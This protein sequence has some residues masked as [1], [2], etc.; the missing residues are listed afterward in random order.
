MNLKYIENNIDNFFLDIIDKRIPQLT[1]EAVIEKLTKTSE[2]IERNNIEVL[3]TKT[4]KRNEIKAVDSKTLF[5]FEECFP[6]AESMQFTI[7]AMKHFRIIDDKFKYI[8]HAQGQAQYLYGV[9][10]GLLFKDIIIRR[11]LDTVYKVICDKIKRRYARISR[12]SKKDGSAYYTAKTE[13]ISYI[14]SKK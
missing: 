9:I 14:N 6:D 11:S 12:P 2:A 5:T 10:D 4:P 7:G 13:I 8:P 1:F 3:S